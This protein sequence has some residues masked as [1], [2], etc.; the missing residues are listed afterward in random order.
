MGFLYDFSN[1]RQRI[2]FMGAAVGCARKIPEVNGIEARPRVI[3]ALRAHIYDRGSVPI[4]P[5]G[6][7]AVPGFRSSALSPVGGS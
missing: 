6:E 4:W 3:Q 5:M 2:Q 7:R 1:R